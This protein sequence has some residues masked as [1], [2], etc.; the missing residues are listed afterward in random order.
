MAK[1]EEENYS[2]WRMTIT[3]MSWHVMYVCITA[4]DGSEDEGERKEKNYAIAI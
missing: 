4:I 3:K 1:E 2:K